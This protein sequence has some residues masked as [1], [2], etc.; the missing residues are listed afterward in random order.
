MMNELT[1]TYGWQSISI[2]ILFFILPLLLLG[3]LWSQGTIGRHMLS[4][5]GYVFLGYCLLILLRV[6]RDA[7]LGNP[8]PVIVEA[9]ESDGAQNLAIATFGWLPPLAYYAIL[10]SLFLIAKG[11][12]YGY[13]S[14]ADRNKSARLSTNVTP[15]ISPA[16]DH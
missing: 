5:A 13:R 4:F 2:V 15:P 7:D 1:Q 3:Y 16:T 6:S 10:L 12:I 8:S 9:Y 11:T 14:I